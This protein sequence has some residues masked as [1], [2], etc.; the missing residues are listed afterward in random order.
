QFP[1]E[2]LGTVSRF[3][4]HNNYGNALC[5]VEGL[6]R[7]A[8][9]VAGV[10]WHPQIKQDRIRLMLEC[11]RES[12]FGHGRVHYFVVGAQTRPHETANRIVVIHNQKLRHLVTSPF[13]ENLRIHALRMARE[14]H[15]QSLRR[16]PSLSREALPR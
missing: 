2:L 3:A 9:F 16:P 13:L 7:S 4:A 10:F 12:F 11:E 14:I 6:E 1:T 15:S 5:G 8:E